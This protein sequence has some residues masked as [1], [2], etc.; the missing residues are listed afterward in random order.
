MDVI[1]KVLDGAKVG[2]KIAVKKDQFLIGRSSKCHLCAGSTAVSRKHCAIS[3]SGTKV[4]IK[5]MGSR[6]GTLVNDE[7]IA[8]EVELSSGDEITVGPLRFLLTIS[9]GINNEKRPQVKSVA[10][11]VDRTVESGDLDIEDDDISRW[12]IEPE[13]PSQSATETQTLSM[14][15]T[16]AIHA[17]LASETEDPSERSNILTP[18][19]VRTDPSDAEEVSGKTKGKKE[20]GKLPPVATG[21]STKDSRD[22]AA[23]ALRNWNRRS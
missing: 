4:L 3:R 10:D 20:P 2:A 17:R 14:D 13:R 22:A 16:N 21:P 18:E 15:E 19:A 23:A 8:G 6:N 1:L 7:K 12:L 5:D 11:A 9:P